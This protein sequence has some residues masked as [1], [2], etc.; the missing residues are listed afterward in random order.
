AQSARAKAEVRDAGATRIGRS[1][2]SL[3]AQSVATPKADAAD[4]WQA[5]TSERAG[6]EQRTTAAGVD[7]I[8]LDG[9]RKA[10]LDR[11]V[12][13]IGTQAAWSAGYTG[14]G[15]KIAV[16]DTGVDGTHP[17]LVGKV[18]AAKNFTSSPNL[19]DRIGHGTH[20]ASIAAG[21]GAKSG[22]K[23][24]GVAPDATLLAGK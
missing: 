21:S 3:N 8:W 4:L 15:V 18:A 1:L 19:R 2:T 11:S 5:L 22:G 9:K 10:T 12:A 16:L 14:K 20:V 7:R 17:D 24:K 6:S 23:F 13:Q